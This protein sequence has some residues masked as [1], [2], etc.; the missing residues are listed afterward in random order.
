[1]RARPWAIWRSPSNALAAAYVKASDLELLPMREAEEC[2]AR[3]VLDRAAALALELDEAE[4][5]E[6]RRRL[7]KE[8]TVTNP[9]ALD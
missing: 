8:P 1:M 9:P 7:A 2:R 5:A 4:I 3:R 6:W